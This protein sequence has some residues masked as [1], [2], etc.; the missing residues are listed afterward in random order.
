MGNQRALI[1]FNRKGTMT[2]QPWL[3]ATCPLPPLGR[4]EG[5]VEGKHT[6]PSVPAGGP[7]PGVDTTFEDEMNRP[8]MSGDSD[9]WEGWSHARRYE[10]AVPG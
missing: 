7:S 3:I 8:G 1:G 2:G 9:C 10:E 6:H 5:V 4:P